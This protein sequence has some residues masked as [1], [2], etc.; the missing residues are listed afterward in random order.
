MFSSCLNLS[1][2]MG[3]MFQSPP[4]F[5]ALLYML[6]IWECIFSWGLFHMS[7]VAGLI[8]YI[9]ARLQGIALS[10]TGS[11][12]VTM[13]DCGGLQYMVT[14]E[15]SVS[16]NRQGNGNL[17]TELTMFILMFIMLHLFLGVSLRSLKPWF[18]P[19]WRKLA[20][21]SVPVVEFE[22]TDYSGQPVCWIVKSF[23]G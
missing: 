19:F 13:L 11:Y 23:F 7:E 16:W 21:W 2:A 8:V 22:T 17:T 10:T 14:H 3:I 1:F 9:I 15:R 18:K 4:V 20:K 5:F 6:S 12:I